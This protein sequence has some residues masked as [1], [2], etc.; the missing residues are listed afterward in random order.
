MENRYVALFTMA[1][2]GGVALG[3]CQEE[4]GNDNGNGGT[5]GGGGNPGAGGSLGTGGNVGTGGNLGADSNVGAG[6]NVGTGNVGTGGTGGTG[7]NGGTGGAPTTPDCELGIPDPITGL[8]FEAASDGAELPLRGSGQTGA[9]AIL[10]VRT[11]GLGETPLFTFVLTRTDA[12]PELDAGVDDDAGVDPEPLPGMATTMWQVQP[13]SGSCGDDG[14]CA[15][16]PVVLPTDGLATPQELN[17]L[18]VE[19]RL[20]VEGDAATC[21]ASLEGVLARSTCGS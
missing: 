2:C 9:R 7:G 17:C 18:D 19:V 14:Y 1:L 11:L 3:G 13:G 12:P 10:A 4:A 6:G 5:G 20:D 21:S 16:V 15:W 8:S